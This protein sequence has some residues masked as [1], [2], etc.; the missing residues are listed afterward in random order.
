SFAYIG[1]RR[2]VLHTGHVARLLRTRFTAHTRNPQTHTTN[3]PRTHKAAANGAALTGKHEPLAF[4]GSAGVSAASGCF[5]CLER[6]VNGVVS[7]QRCESTSPLRERWHPC[8][9]IVPRVTRRQ[10]CRRPSCTGNS[11]FSCV[12]HERFH[13][14]CFNCAPTSSGR[15][16]TGMEP[17]S[18]TAW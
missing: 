11:W 3:P 8:R 9:R 12:R 2:L 16:F 13:F 1:R 7:I 17:C 4:L 14:G 18:N 5:Q 10:G 6:I 15:Y